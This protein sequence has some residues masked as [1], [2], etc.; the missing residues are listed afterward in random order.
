MTFKWN[1]YLIPDQLET[2]FQLIS[3]YGSNA[4]IVAGGTD[5]VLAMN[6]GKIT[7][8]EALIDISRIPELKGISID[9]GFLQI[10]ACT[11]LTEL[12]KNDLVLEKAPILSYAAKQVA[13]WQI[14][15]LATL[16]GNVV[17]ASP[18]ADMIPPLMTLDAEVTIISSHGKRRSEN[19]EKFLLGYRKVDLQQGELVENFRFAARPE[20]FYIFRKVQPRRSMA[21]AILNLAILVNIE[22][23]EIKDLRI[24][25]GAVAPTAVR[26]HGIENKLIGMR[27]DQP[28][29]ED[30][31]LVV[32]NE[33][34]PIGDF[35]ASKK[36]RLNVAR[37]LVSEQLQEIFLTT[38]LKLQR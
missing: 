30:I 26:L 20:M 1:Q 38:N 27:I 29:E 17:N 18:A 33:I 21:I 2:A 6:E 25:M 5:L 10:G 15:N 12:V 13:G 31:F 7:P 32:S 3:Q 8:I 14:R 9:N 19:L 22:F 16:G 36:Y 4:R 35:R 37:N 28:I 24:A 11:S 23:N 34:S